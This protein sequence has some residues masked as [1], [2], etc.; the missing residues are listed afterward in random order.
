MDRLK[1]WSKSK[2][3]TI[4]WFYKSASL[5]IIDENNLNISL[6]HSMFTDGTSSSVYIELLPGLFFMLQF[7]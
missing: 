6:A 7:L 3:K 2:V 1:W 5:Y 4:C